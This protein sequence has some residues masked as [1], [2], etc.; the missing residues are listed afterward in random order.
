MKERE[1]PLSA[2]ATRLSGRTE[3]TSADLSAILDLPYQERR[4]AVG[5]Y[6]VQEGE[7]SGNCQVMLTGFAHRHRFSA[8]G[9]RHI[10]GIHGEGDILNLPALPPARAED[11][12]QALSMVT[13]A[14]I[15]TE[16]LLALCRSHPGIANALWAEVD[17]NLSVVR[18][19][20]ANMGRRD[21]RG[22][23]A[24]LFC[25]LS[26][27]DHRTGGQDGCE[28][29]LPLTQAELADATGMTTVHVNRTLRALEAEGFIDRD[30]RRIIV[31]NWRRLA[32]LAD[33]RMAPW[34]ARTGVVVK[35]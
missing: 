4:V 26:M 1:H 19:W 11:F 22:R 14:A 27:R 32:E 12:V 35:G 16:S 31:P 5:D 18:A 23:I 29:V 7:R 33:F 20:I 21:A 13:V 28:I 15:P 30:R 34:T 6:L 25:E 2:L 8:E 17:A 3:L 10:V 24:H 9:L